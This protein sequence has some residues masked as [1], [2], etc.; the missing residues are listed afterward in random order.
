MNVGMLWFD[1][2]PR[3]ALT[4]KVSR[5]ADYYRQKYG[6]IADLCLVHPSMLGASTPNLEEVQAGKVAV[7]PNRSILP[8]HLWI[9]N[10]EKNQ[11]TVN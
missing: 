6:L 9:G 4:A 5:A 11:K 8:G 7:R 2:D 3:T 1:N 10:E